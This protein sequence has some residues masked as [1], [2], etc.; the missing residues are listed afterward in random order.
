MLLHVHDKKMLRSPRCCICTGLLGAESCLASLI[1]Y[2]LMFFWGPQRAANQVAA[3]ACNLE[4][5]R[6]QNLYDCNQNMAI[7]LTSETL[8]CSLGRVIV[9][10]QIMARQSQ[11]DMIKDWFV[12][13]LPSLF[14]SCC[15]QISSFQLHK[16]Y[17][18]WS[19]S[20]NTWPTDSLSAI[21]TLVYS[22]T[23]RY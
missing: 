16:H 4:T 23:N 6:H 12:Q 14:D 8:G 15:R 11:T 10:K 7:G 17:K 5:Q 13:L 19:A 1:V 21:S 20:W 9:P 18:S 2:F 22:I 3:A